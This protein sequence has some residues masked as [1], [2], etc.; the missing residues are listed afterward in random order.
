[1]R[2]SD[3]LRGQDNRW[4]EAEGCDVFYIGAWSQR[5]FLLSEKHHFLMRRLGEVRTD[6]IW[7]LTLPVFN[8]GPNLLVAAGFH[9][10]EPAGCWGVLRFLDEAP[11]DLLRRVNLSFLPLVTP[12]DSV[13][14][15]E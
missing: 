7:L 9:G 2:H 10:E 5:L 12:L 3:P 6:T 4:L 1:M 14:R 15:R 13:D 11:P 8:D